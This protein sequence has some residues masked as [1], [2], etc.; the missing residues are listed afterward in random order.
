MKILVTGSEGLL[1][2]QIIKLSHPDLDYFGASKETLDVTNTKNVN[3]FFKNNSF[4]LIIHC[5]AYTAVDQAETDKERCYDV[6]V[7]GTK[8][9]AKQASK[10]NIP[11]VY[12]SSDYVFDGNKTTPYSFNDLKNPI[13]YYGYTKSLGEDVVTSTL[14]KYYII[15]V[16]WLFGALGHNFVNTMLRLM[17]QRDSLNVIND[18]IGSPT[19]VKDVADFISFIVKSDKYGIYHFTNEGFCSWYDYALEI[20]NHIG[21]LGTIH[22]ISSNQ[23]RTNASRPQYSVLKKDYTLGYHYR[24]WKEA[25]HECLDRKEGYGFE[26]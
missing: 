4:D 14:S 26:E 16:S 19:Y 5:A 22:P 21:Y 7:K 1:G 24:T 18:Q 8:N 13:N 20:A 11:M 10:H 9:I 15:R 2:Q 6:N 17:N 25:L 12:I 3:L 23:Y